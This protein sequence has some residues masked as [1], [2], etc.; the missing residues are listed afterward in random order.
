MRLALLVLATVFSPAC[1]SRVDSQVASAPSQKSVNSP[2]S[3]PS[4]YTAKAK[5]EDGV[6]TFVRT[7]N[8]G[9][10]LNLNVVR[11]A[12]TNANSFDLYGKK[13]TYP[14]IRSKCVVPGKD[15]SCDRDLKNPK[16]GDRIDFGNPLKSVKST[17]NQVVYQGQWPCAKV[18]E[19]VSERPTKTNS[20]CAITA[21]IN[22]KKNIVNFTVKVQDGLSLTGSGYDL[23][24][25]PMPFVNQPLQKEVVLAAM[26]RIR[27]RWPDPAIGALG[28][29]PLNMNMG[30]KENVSHSTIVGCNENFVPWWSDIVTH[31]Y[32][33]LPPAGIRECFTGSVR[34]GY[35]FKYRPYFTPLP[36]LEGS[37]F[38]GAF[39]YCLHDGS[40]DKE[41]PY[42]QRFKDLND[43]PDQG[44]RGNY[45]WM[46]LTPVLDDSGQQFLNSEGKAITHSDVFEYIMG[47]GVA[48]GSKLDLADKF[49][50]MSGELGSKLFALESAWQEHARKTKA[51]VEKVAAAN[52]SATWVDT[53][54]AN[55]ANNIAQISSNQGWNNC[56]Y[57]TDQ[58]TCGNDPSCRWDK[59]DTTGIC[60]KPSSNLC[61]SISAKDTCTAT[62]ECVIS[63][64]GRC[65]DLASSGN[66]DLIAAEAELVA[67]SDVTKKMTAEID[68]MKGQLK[69]IRE[70][71]HFNDNFSTLSTFN[72]DDQQW[73]INQ[74]FNMNVN[75]DQKVCEPEVS[76]GV[77]SG[78][79]VPP[80]G[81]CCADSRFYRF[82]SEGRTAKVRLQRNIKD[83]R[84]QRENLCEKDPSTGNCLTSGSVKFAN[85]C[86]AAPLPS[87]TV[88]NN[89]EM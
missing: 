66:A 18:I 24:A 84:G 86:K 33:Q 81:T 57:L 44:T 36:G 32:C 61:A 34:G 43:I 74:F 49:D 89:P 55:C 2:S 40:K 50:R 52:A 16:F 78:Y 56:K 87:G 47:S 8:A 25:L 20:Q 64:A 73:V 27:E 75:A 26:K 29:S 6:L 11:F 31:Y 35:D 38:G 5:L 17:G 62:T 68:R 53:D 45:K 37:S 15:W 21:R 77:V 9:E 1:K 19:F 28:A 58:S 46:A 72:N 82:G 22:K 12:D 71:M 85:V 80:D 60:L 83:E 4:E 63:S 65:S 69:P 79:K 10:Y 30:T 14:A 42:Y 76:S 54:P 41:T 23:V 13:A 70:E 48:M 51:L 3:A 39:D 88:I 59:C 7:K 67:I